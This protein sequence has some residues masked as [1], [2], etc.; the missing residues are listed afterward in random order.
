MFL[1]HFYLPSF[2]FSERVCIDKAHGTDGG[3][4]F[5][6][7]GDIIDTK[8]HWK[9]ELIRK[10]LWDTKCYNPKICIWRKR[11]QKLKSITIFHF[12]ITFHK[13]V[14]KIKTGWATRVIKPIL[15]ITLHKKWSF[16]LRISSVNATK[17]A[18]SCEF[19]HSYWTNTK[20]KTSFFV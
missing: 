19:R 5:P 10:A 13:F 1:R 14:F 18:V 17:F 8:C 12:L 16:L 11:V 15:K 2:I 20:W 4:C 3:I 6:K 9:I 7:N